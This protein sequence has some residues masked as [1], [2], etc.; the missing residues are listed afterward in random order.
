VQKFEGAVPPS[1]EN[2][3]FKK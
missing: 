3:I 1:G 2:I